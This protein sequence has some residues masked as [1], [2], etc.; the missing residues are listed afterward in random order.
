[1]KVFDLRVGRVLSF[2][3]VVRIGTPPTPHRRVCP[4]P[5][6]SGG[7]AHSLSREGVGESNSV[8]GTYI[9]VFC[10]FVFILT[11]QVLVLPVSIDLVL[12]KIM[13]I[14]NQ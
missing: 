12:N 8:V 14:K 2:S 11:F 13:F 6:G 7:G 1:M 5:L 10:D 4:P 9:Y 3:P